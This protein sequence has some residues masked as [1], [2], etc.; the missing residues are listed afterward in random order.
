MHH[1]YM[2]TNKYREI[3]HVLSAIAKG[4]DQLTTREFAPAVRLKE[5]TVRKAHRLR[6]LRCGVVPF[7]VG[8]ALLWPVS[9][10]LS[11]FANDR[12]SISNKRLP[13]KA[14]AATQG[15]PEDLK[16]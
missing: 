16:I 15:F 7:I 10:V 5:G 12:Y 9:D 13:D 8:R 2:D 6:G 14:Q 4:K 1:M 11:M 3:P